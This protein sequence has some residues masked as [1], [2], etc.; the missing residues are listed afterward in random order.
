MSHGRSGS[1]TR[2][3]R[4]AARSH[5]LAGAATPRRPGLRRRLLVGRLD[6][7]GRHALL[8][9]RVERRDARV[10]CVY[11]DLLDGERRLERL[12]AGVLSV[13][14]RHALVRQQGE[15]GAVVFGPDSETPAGGE[16]DGR[17]ERGP[18]GLRGPPTSGRFG[19][20]RR[21]RS[22]LAAAS[23]EKRRAGREK[24]SPL[25]TRGSSTAAKYFV[26]WRRGGRGR[27]W[28]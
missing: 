15:D 5:A 17:F 21:T 4:P 20:V 23:R 26:H 22:G 6:R 3:R 18:F 24:R 7:L 12:L 11:R 28:R 9:L 13:E 19:H 1:E 16:L 14:L 27:G 10:R 25:H 2:A 8:V